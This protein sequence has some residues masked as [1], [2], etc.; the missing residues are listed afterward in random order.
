MYPVPL[1]FVVVLPTSSVYI[2]V[3]HKVVT[4]SLHLFGSEDASCVR[5]GRCV[6]VKLCLM[7][8]SCVNVRLNI[9]LLCFVEH[10]L[11]AYV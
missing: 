10:C 1:F 9:S 6:R 3:K 2:V 7:G 11:F 8:K 5:G 4:I